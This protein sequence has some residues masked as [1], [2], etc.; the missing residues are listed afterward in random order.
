MNRPIE[1]ATRPKLAL[2]SYLD[3][4]LQDATAELEEPSVSVDEFQAA[5]LEEQAL[6]LRAK[7]QVKPVAVAVAAPAPVA[8]PVVAAAPVLVPAPVVVSAPVVAEKIAVVEAPV[9]RAPTL[10]LVEPVAELSAPVG[11]R[12][13]TPPPT[14]EGRP[15]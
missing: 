1:V 8:V 15:A 6:D 9:I 13:P 11:Q 14:L 2:Q 4:L 5:V 10:E 7:T 12:T 3:A